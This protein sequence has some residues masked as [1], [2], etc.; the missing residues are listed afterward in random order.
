[1]VGKIR[2]DIHVILSHPSVDD[3]EIRLKTTTKYQYDSWDVVRVSDIDPE[4]KIPKMKIKHSEDDPKVREFLKK[5]EK[6]VDS[7]GWETVQ[8]KRKATSPRH[9]SA[10]RTTRTPDRN[11]SHSVKQILQRNCNRPINH[12]E[13]DDSSDE[14]YDEDNIMSEDYDNVRFNEAEETEL[15]QTEIDHDVQNLQEESVAGHNGLNLV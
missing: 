12:D 5:K 3:W 14:S 13:E 9:N 10:K 8:G 15:N 6:I 11:I 7:E 2:S 1:M 4:N